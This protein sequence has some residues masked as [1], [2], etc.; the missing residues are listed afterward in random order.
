[1]SMIAAVSIVAVLMLQQPAPP[2]PSLDFEYFR[3][4]VQPIFTTKR[5]GNARCVSCHS[6]GTTM[7][8][9]PLPPKSATWNEEDSRKNFEA[10]RQKV[11]PGDPAKSRL[12]M[13]R[14][15]GSAGGD[16]I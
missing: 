14:L 12:L 4:R 10:V 7:R 6:V 5:T 16:P 9:Q 8:L 15:A 13:H 1:M 2:A 3:E 11:I